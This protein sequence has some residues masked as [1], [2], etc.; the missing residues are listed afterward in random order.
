MSDEMSDIVN[1]LRKFMFKNVYLD[2]R[3]KREGIKV[4]HMLKSLYQYYCEHTEKM[5]N[6]YHLY[7]E[8][9]RIYL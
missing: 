2:L 6:Y 7:G 1:R 4:D 9:Y 3:A 8:R 5:E